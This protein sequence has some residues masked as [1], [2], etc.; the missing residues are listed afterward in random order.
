[1]VETFVVS[2]WLEHLRQ[3]ERVT[4]ESRELQ[5]LMVAFHIG[6]IPPVVSH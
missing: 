6:P 2:F 4:Q 5:E 1:V 3:H